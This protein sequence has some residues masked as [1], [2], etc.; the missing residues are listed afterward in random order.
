MRLF[1]K[2]PQ[3]GDQRQSQRAQSLVVASSSGKSALHSVNRTT[4]HTVN[5][6]ASRTATLDSTTNHTA[7][8]TGRRS[9]LTSRKRSFRSPKIAL[10]ESDEEDDVS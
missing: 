7:D 4:N 3:P 9:A 8:R 1:T 2:Q 5:H 6:T 10:D